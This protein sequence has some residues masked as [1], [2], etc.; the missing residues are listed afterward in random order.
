M[1]E[2]SQIIIFNNKRKT[3]I[4]FTEIVIMTGKLRVYDLQDHL[5]HKA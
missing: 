5:M 3:F 1:S 2:M 4:L